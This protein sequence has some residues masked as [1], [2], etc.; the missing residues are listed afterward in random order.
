MN[1]EEFM[2]RMEQEVASKVAGAITRTKVK[3]NN[4]IVLDGLWILQTYRNGLCVN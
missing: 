1:Y 4:G 2:N 3:K